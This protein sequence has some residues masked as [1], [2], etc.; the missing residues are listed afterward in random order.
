MNVLVTGGTGF[1]GSHLVRALLARGDTVHAT[2]RNSALPESIADLRYDTRLVLHEIDIADT[3]ALDAL[4]DEVKPERIYHLAACL[5]QRGEDP[6][7]EELTATNVV[8]TAAL[9][10]YA[11]AQGVP[12]VNTG[13]FT[14][15]QPTD[16]PVDEDSRLG[17]QEFY[18]TSKLAATLLCTQEG[19]KGAPVVTLRLFTP[20][21]PGMQEGRL[22]RVAVENALAGKPITL[23]SPRVTRDFVFVEDIA[24]AYLRAGERAAARPGAVWNIGT[25]VAT[26]LDDFGKLVLELTGSK[27]PI[28]WGEQKKL[29]YDGE[30]WQADNMRAKNDLGWGPSYD[31]RAGLQKTI[32]WY[33]RNT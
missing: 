9:V 3:K 20:Y 26:R 25:G 18:S 5:H 28:A 27:S 32:A 16:R 19:K 12:M 15:Y 13:T 21:G 1:I 22:V 31:L 8:A 29:A 30:L 17:P 24:D 33:K 23:S 10:R 7:V 2:T 14:E 11:K 4:L 6:P